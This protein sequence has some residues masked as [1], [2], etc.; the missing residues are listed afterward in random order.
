MTTPSASGYVIDASVGIKLFIAEPLSDKTHALFALLATDPPALFYVP[1]LFYVECVNIL[2]KAVNRLGLPAEDAQIFVEQ[3]GKL[4]LTSVPTELLISDALAL[5]LRH[6][7][8]AYGAC[9]VVLAAQLGRPLIT[10]DEKLVRA[11][12]KTGYDVRWLGDWS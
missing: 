1:D 9:Y 3:L 7:V 6:S 12:S 10:A 8:T 5:S 11:F 4:T 2:W